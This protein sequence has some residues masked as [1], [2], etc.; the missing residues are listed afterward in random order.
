M[1][2]TPKL[3]IQNFYKVKPVKLVSR[4][5][6]ILLLER[7]FLKTLYQG[8]NDGDGLKNIAVINIRCK[9]DITWKGIHELYCYTEE[10]GA[11]LTIETFF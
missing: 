7:N 6:K 4:I 9:K 10:E 2:S 3:D 11:L 5:F 8:L 1:Y